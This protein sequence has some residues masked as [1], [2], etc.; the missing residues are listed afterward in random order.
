MAMQIEEIRSA[1]LVAAPELCKHVFES[2]APRLLQSTGSLRSDRSKTKD[3]NDPIWKTITLHGIEIDLL[4]LPLMQRLRRIRQLGLAHLVFPGAN[5]TRLEH[6][7]GALHAAKQIFEKLE[8][9]SDVR[10]DE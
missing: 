3:F 5:H 7:V 8:S 2:L 6:S 4:N 1:L 10:D 9:S